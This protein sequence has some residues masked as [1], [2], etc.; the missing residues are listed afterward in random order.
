GHAL[1]GD[2]L[3]GSAPKPLK[4]LLKQIGFARQA[5]HA[6]ELGFVHP[7][8]KQFVSFTAPVPNDMQELIDELGRFN[9]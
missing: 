1:L 4:P 7:L 2:P 8:S 3:Y 5:L 9:R 6:A